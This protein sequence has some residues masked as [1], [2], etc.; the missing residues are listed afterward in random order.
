V[1]V[2]EVRSEVIRFSQIRDVP[3]VETE[4]VVGSI[5]P[6][7]RFH[8]TYTITALVDCPGMEW[9]VGREC[10][11]GKTGDVCFANP[12]E[13][14][15]VKALERPQTFVSIMVS[16]EIMEEA[17]AAR[18]FERRPLSW[19]GAQR[20]DE[21]LCSE[22]IRQHRALEEA[23]AGPD[24]AAALADCLS[25]LFARCIDRR[26]A[27]ASTPPR[28]TVER[29]RSYLEHNYQQQFGMDELAAAVGASRYHLARTFAAE[30]GVT[31]HEYLLQVRLARA[32]ALLSQDI[33]VQ[34][35][36]A[37]TGFSDQSHFTRH[38]RRVY[39]VTPMR[40]V[41]AIRNG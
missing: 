9:R 21:S 11:S 10:G 8:E 29:A 35:A 27:T 33:P 12:G 30:F 1:P 22:V 25:L 23:A 15:L 34:R 3:G 18:H 24:A 14:T 20:A 2:A 41:A 4:R 16:K 31:P 26:A 37:D 36:A 5:R 17:A 39:G 38:F 6:W 7:R 28:P 32:R 13:L 40:Y 19:R